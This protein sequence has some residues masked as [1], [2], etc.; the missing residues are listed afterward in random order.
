MMDF[1]YNYTSAPYNCGHHCTPF[2]EFVYA[3][4]YSKEYIKQINTEE[5]GQRGKA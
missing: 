5:H 4:R 2:K 1:R 3:L